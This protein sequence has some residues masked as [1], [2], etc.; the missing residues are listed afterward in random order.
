MK[1]KRSSQPRGDKFK[2]IC[3]RIKKKAEAEGKNCHAKIVLTL[4]KPI[5]II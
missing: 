4:E 3:S 1:S 2:F 5:K